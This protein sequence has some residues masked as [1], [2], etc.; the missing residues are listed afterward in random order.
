MT[1]AAKDDDGVAEQYDAY[2]ANASQAPGPSVN[3][4][5]LKTSQFIYYI[6]LPLEIH[7]CVHAKKLIHC[8][9]FSFLSPLEVL[10]RAATAFIIQTQT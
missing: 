8:F 7:I 2:S 9:H 1:I 5:P 6:C 4:F 3:S 10:R